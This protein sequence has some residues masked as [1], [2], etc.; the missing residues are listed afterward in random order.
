MTIRELK[1]VELLYL[2]LELIMFK[3]YYKFNSSHFKEKIQVV[4][5]LYKFKK[6]ILKYLIS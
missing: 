5:N 2:I 3:S 4:V 6:L 1:L